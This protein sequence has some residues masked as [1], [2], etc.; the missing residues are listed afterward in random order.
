MLQSNQDY[1]FTQFFQVIKSMTAQQEEALNKKLEEFI[2][3][4]TLE[5]EERSEFNNSLAKIKRH[6]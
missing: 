6:R 4:V 2:F 1:I 5:D 3:S